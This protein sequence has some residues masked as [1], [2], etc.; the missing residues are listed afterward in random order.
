MTYI[1]SGL[2]TRFFFALTN[3]G[4]KPKSGGPNMYIYEGGPKKLGGAFGPPTSKTGGPFGK[5]GCQWPL[6]PVSFE[7]CII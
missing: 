3:R 1:I 4:P 6:G 7:P 2:E 5:S